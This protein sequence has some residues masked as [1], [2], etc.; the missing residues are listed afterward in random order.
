MSYKARVP[1][2]SVSP[3]GQ[4]PRRDFGDVGALARSIEATGGQPVNP[5]VVAD[6]GD[7]ADG[8]PLYRIVDGERRWRALVE[9]GAQEADVLVCA[10]WSEAEEAVAMMAT[11]DK[12]ALTDQER[13]RGFQG[14]LSLG[15]PDETVSGASGVEVAA[16]RRVRRMV[17]SEGFEAPEQ[18]TM[19]ALIAASGLD[20]P[21]D[22]ARVMGS[23][24]P[25]REAERI[26]RRRE[27]EASRARLRGEVEASGLDV[28]WRRGA[29]PWRFSASLREMGLAF[30]AEVRSGADV[31]GLAASSPGQL[32]A[33]ADGPGWSLFRVVDGAAEDLRQAELEGVRR[34]SRAAVESFSRSVA[35]WAAG[36][37]SVPRDLASLVRERRGEWS[38]RR[39]LGV[40]D[41][42]ADAALAAAMDS[43]PSVYELVRALDLTWAY[44]VRGY[45]GGYEDDHAREAQDLWDA[46]VEGG[47]DPAGCEALAAE[48]AAW[49]ESGGEVPADAVG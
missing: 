29:A 1:L 5:I 45:G 38:A 27:E 23:A 42:E 3:S 46:A 24:D 17:R 25:G 28:D 44:G 19:D 18:C 48:L 36:L 14:M 47:W 7:G 33:Y 39:A 49:R 31:A 30:E 40:P 8:E 32:A 21:R 13:A 22:R 2:S 16:V 10:D 35:R 37:G 20:D 11:D 6:V 12:K 41:G 34:G 4:N 9:L 43:E 15:V 26:R